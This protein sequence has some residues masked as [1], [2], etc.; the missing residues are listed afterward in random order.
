MYEQQLI[1][2]LSNDLSIQIGDSLDREEIQLMV[3]ERVSEL[4]QKDFHGLITLLYRLDV[5]EEKLKKLLETNQ[6]KDAADIIS[7]L[8]VERQLQR[9]KSRND[10]RS[11][12]NVSEEEKW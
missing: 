12:N 7:Q 8:I 1:L 5:S 3:R 11:N 2:S 4:L 9:I 6:D 10:F